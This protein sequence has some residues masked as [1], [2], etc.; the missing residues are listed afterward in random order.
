MKFHICVRGDEILGWIYLQQVSCS[1]HKDVHL[2][3]EKERL[4]ELHGRG[5]NATSPSLTK[6][7][8][9]T[10]SSQL[11]FSRSVSNFHLPLF[12]MCMMHWPARDIRLSTK[13][14]DVF[15]VCL[16][17]LCSR[18]LHLPHSTLIPSKNKHRR[19]DLLEAVVRPVIQRNLTYAKK[20]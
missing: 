19:Q 3:T 17:C 10:D 8:V 18:F 9:A 20:I 1:L 15:S 4:W 13:L 11:E 5:T 2:C 14:R 12:M 7:G 6:K 16:L